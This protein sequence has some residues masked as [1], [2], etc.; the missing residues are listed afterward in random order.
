MF[1]IGEQ[2]H[3]SARARCSPDN[4]L[5]FVVDD[6]VS[7]RESIESLVRCAGWHCETFGSAEQFLA[8]PRAG[9]PSCLVLDYRL[10]QLDGLGLQRQ[11]AADGARLPIIFMT[12]FADPP[13]AVEAMKGGALEL[14]IKPFCDD[15]LLAA[16][17]QGIARSAAALRRDAELRRLRHCYDS[18]SSRERQIMARVVAGR[19][20]KQIASELVISEITVKAHRG[21]MMQKMQA[22]SLAQLVNMAIKL[23]LE[24]MPVP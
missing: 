15:A 21:H 16:I 8:R 22:D 2:G 23:N 17:H 7:M 3:E 12:Y 14:L 19:L 6:D 1:S 9:V 24:S 4:P 18:L 20:N 13:M 5:V 11:L 10:P